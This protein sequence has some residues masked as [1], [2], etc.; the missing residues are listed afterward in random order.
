M[1]SL[2]QH[3]LVPAPILSET[4]SFLYQRGREGCEG[5]LLWIGMQCDQD[6]QITRVFI[7]EQR[8][9]KTRLGVAVELTPHAHFTLPDT[10]GNLEQFYVRVHSHPTEAYHSHR[11]NQN[12]VLTHEG[13]LSIVVPDFAA[14]SVLNLADCAIYQLEYGKGWVRLDQVAIAQR[15]EVVS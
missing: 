1:A 9:I 10:L 13:A 6:V 12:A 8:C 14:R 2:D 11:D 4:R 7:P 15:I 3:Y 5:M